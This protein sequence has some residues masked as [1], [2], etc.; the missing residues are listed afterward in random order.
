MAEVMNNK[1]NIQTA[2][3]DFTCNHLSNLSPQNKNIPNP[4]M[5]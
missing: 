5:N 1:G 2:M 3:G 4:I